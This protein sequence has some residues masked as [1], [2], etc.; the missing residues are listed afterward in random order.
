MTQTSSPV[1]TEH[2]S[3]GTAMALSL[4]TTLGGVVL[5]S[6][7][8][9]Q[10]NDSGGGQAI[11]MVGALA[12]AI[13]PTLGH[14]YAGATW[15]GGLGM[16]LA[17]TGMAFVGFMTAFMACPLFGPCTAEQQ[18]KADLGGVIAVGGGLLYGA[19]LV[20]EIASVPAAVR[21]HN[22]AAHHDHLSANLT[23]T[24]IR[25]PTTTSPGIALVGRF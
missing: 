8:S 20:Y 11:G 7:G 9:A 2:K 1:P 3:V 22:R 24:P 19:G 12:I 6:L 23:I 25:T 18:S 4:G 16:R 15:N 10:S 17:G 14:A 13:G 21:E 5:F